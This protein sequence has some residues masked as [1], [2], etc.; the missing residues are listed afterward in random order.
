[1]ACGQNASELLTLHDLSSTSWIQ[2]EEW[3]VLDK[4]FKT[5][6]G[7]KCQVGSRSEVFLGLQRNRTMVLP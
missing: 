3:R 1:M 2:Q 5:S 6:R 7:Q 4:T